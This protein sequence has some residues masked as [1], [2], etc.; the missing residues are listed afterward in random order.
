MTLPS[1]HHGEQIRSI[2][3]KP[4]SKISIKYLINNLTILF[5][6]RLLSIL[7]HPIPFDTNKILN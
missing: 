5:L 7:I 2:Q 3:F 4:S 1:S 6:H